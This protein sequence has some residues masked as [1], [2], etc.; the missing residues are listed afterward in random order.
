MNQTNTGYS[1]VYSQPGACPSCGMTPWQPAAQGAQAQTVS[2]QSQMA[3]Q[4]PPQTMPAMPATISPTPY[5]QQVSFQQPA[6]AAPSS[7]LTQGTISGAAGFVPNQPPESFPGAI[8]DLNQPMPMT[9]ESLQY[10]NGFMR[11]Q[12]GR[13]VRV[14]FLL[15]TNTMTDR[16]GTLLGVGANYIL[17]NETDSD[18][19]LA[20]D[21]Y[22]IKFIRFYF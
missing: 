11:T 20:C 7:A 9:V 2:A 13:R 10:L 12:I 14:E 19:L 4:I 8:T 3:A 21:F 6:G 17:I 15:G 1:A 18:D 5:Q 16:T 22:N